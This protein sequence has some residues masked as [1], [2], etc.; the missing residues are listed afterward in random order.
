MV[1]LILHQQNYSKQFFLNTNSQ[2][3]VSNFSLRTKNIVGKIDDN[4]FVITIDRLKLLNDFKINARESGLN[5]NYVDVKISRS[6]SDE[7]LPSYGLFAF[8]DDG[9]TCTA[10][11]LEL[12]DSTFLISKNG[13]TITCTSVD[14]TGLGCTPIQNGLVWTCTSCKKPCTKT[15]TVVIKS[16]TMD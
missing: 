10:I 8:S 14:C 16:L 5:V 7:S 3:T 13:A 6:N 15:A 2:T 12:K 9:V 11:E 1:H 4:S